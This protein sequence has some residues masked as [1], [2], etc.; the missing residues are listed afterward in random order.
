MLARRSPLATNRWRDGTV[1]PH[2]Y[3]HLEHFRL[4]GA[5]PVWTYAWADALVEKRVWMP[6]GENTTYVHYQLK[7]S[8]RSSAPGWRR[9]AP[10]CDLMDRVGADMQPGPS[11]ANPG[12]T[13]AR[14]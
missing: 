6:P 4:E 9:R 13:R 8:P 12:R 14:L 1:A 10:M 7:R 2:G 5:T 11:P 3:R